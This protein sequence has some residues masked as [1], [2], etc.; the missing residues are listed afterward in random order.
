MGR[1][2]IFAV[3]VAFDSN[4]TKNTIHVT[5]GL[6]KKRKTLKFLANFVG[7]FIETDSFDNFCFAF[8]R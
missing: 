8:R 2:A 5:N 6:A 1:D 4:C 7:N 3:A